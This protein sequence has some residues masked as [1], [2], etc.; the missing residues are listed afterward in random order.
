LPNPIRQKFTFITINFLFGEFI[1]FVL[2][3]RPT[4]AILYSNEAT[5][6]D[7]VDDLAKTCTFMVQVF[8]TAKRTRT[9]LK[10][11]AKGRVRYELFIFS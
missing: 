9:S 11:T 3:N 5:R 7:A 6:N 2:T 4:S 10:M 8:S 1:L